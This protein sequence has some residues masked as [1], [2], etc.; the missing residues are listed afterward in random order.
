MS[1]K[2]AIN[3][4]LQGSVPTYLRCGGVVNNCIKN[5]LLLSL[6]VNF[7]KSASIWQSY[8]QKRDC[9][10]H[11]LSSSSVLARRTSARD[12]RVLACNLAK[13]TPTL[14]FFTRRLSNKLFKFSY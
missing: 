14:I 6:L 9:F 7:F 5:G 3:D 11:F 13:Y 1:A 12:N 8:K 10:V 4:R 2:Q